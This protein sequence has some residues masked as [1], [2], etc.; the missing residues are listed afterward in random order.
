MILAISC[1]YLIACDVYHVFASYLLR[2]TVVNKMI[3]H[4]NFNKVFPL[5]MRHYESSLFGS[6]LLEIPL[7]MVHLI[8]PLMAHLW[9]A[10]NSTPLVIFTNGA[11]PGAPLVSGILMAHRGCAI[12]IGQRAPLVCLPGAMYTQVLWHTNGAPPLD[13]P[14]VTM[15]Y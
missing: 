12:S 1:H 9:C 3:P 4:N 10:I 13:A 14:L 2:T 5:T 6:T 15:A 11:P 7:L 8:W